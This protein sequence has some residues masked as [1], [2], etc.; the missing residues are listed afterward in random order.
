LKA[1]IIGKSEL[2]WPDLVRDYTFDILTDD[3][4]VILGSQSV[5]ARPS[6]ISNKILEI[7]AEYQAVFEEVNDV[8]VGSEIS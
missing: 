3:G 7:V 5:V 4:D 2:R 1:K 8:E 6:E